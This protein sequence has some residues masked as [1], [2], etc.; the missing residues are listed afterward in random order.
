M[1]ATASCKY[2]LQYPWVKN[3]LDPCPYGYICMQDQKWSLWGNHP[4][5][6][7]ECMTNIQKMKQFLIRTH[8]QTAL[9]Q[10]LAI[11]LVHGD[12]ASIVNF[13]SPPKPMNIGIWWSMNRGTQLC[14]SIDIN[15]DHGMKL[16]TPLPRK[17]PRLQKLTQ[18][19]LG[20]VDLLRKF[21]VQV[22]LKP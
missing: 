6:I 15:H 7:Q 22:W 5:H 8:L 19:L 9:Q 3:C 18:K 17:P 14:P 21:C 11:Q 20:P 4:S 13:F 12:Y 2:D 10:S 16:C 1:I